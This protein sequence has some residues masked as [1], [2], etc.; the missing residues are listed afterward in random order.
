LALALRPGFLTAEYFLEHRAR[1]VAPFRLYLALSLV[2]FSFAT[3]SSPRSKRGPGALSDE[4]ALTEGKRELESAAAQLRA[5][6]GVPEEAVAALERAATKAAEARPGPVGL[7]VGA[8]GAGESL[9]DKACE[10]IRLGQSE[11]VRMALVETCKRN[12][13]D[14]GQTLARG[15]VHNVP[16]MMFVFL[17]LM[18]LVMGALYRRPRRYY[19]EHLVFFLHTHAAVFLLFAL[20][21]ALSRFAPVLRP[22]SFSLWLSCWM[23]AVTLWAWAGYY[24]Y[25]AMRTY[26][27]QGRALTAAKFFAVSLAY[28]VFLSVTLL[29]TVAVSAIWA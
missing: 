14:Q 28:L 11:A 3:C 1:Y 22:L 12:L 26:Y 6:P 20:S 5:T 10:E 13:R 7:R 16:R 23:G 25:G 17:P 24:V 4:E 15:V 9:S 27:G 29:G 19:V 2:F 8:A 18:A 21:L